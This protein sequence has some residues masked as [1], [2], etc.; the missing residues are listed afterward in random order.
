MNP[1]V[2]ILFIFV[3]G[4]ATGYSIHDSKDK[5]EIHEEANKIFQEYQDNRISRYNISIIQN[6]TQRIDLP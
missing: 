6:D 5:I 4:V 2:V 1:A 3:I